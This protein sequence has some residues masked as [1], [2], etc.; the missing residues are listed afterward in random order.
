M[1]NYSVSVVPLS[2]RPAMIHRPVNLVIFNHKDLTCRERHVKVNVQMVTIQIIKV[3]DAE[4]AVGGVSLVLTFKIARSVSAVI[5][6]RDFAL[7]N[8]LLSSIRP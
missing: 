4:S 2:V 3:L 5:Y 6:I 1:V 8:A 7:C